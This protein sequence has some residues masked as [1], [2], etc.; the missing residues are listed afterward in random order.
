MFVSRFFEKIS[1]KTE[2]NFFSEEFYYKNDFTEKFSSD[3][4][5]S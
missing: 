4:K 2:N 1:V 3:T 5:I